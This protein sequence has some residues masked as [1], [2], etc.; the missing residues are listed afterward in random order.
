MVQTQNEKQQRY[1][2]KQKA[3]KTAVHEIESVLNKILDKAVLNNCSIE[4][5]CNAQHLIQM[6]KIIGK[7]K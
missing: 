1:R 5:A 7:A 3:Y 6:M 4:E 2:E